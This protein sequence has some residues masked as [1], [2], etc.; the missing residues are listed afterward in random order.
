MTAF[1]IQASSEKGID[2][3]KLI[4]KYGCFP[5]TQEMLYA[6]R[7]CLV[8]KLT[9]FYAEEFSSVKETYLKCWTST[10]SMSHFI[11]TQDVAQ[12]R[13]L[14]I[15][16]TQYLSCS[17]STCRMR[18]TFHLSSKSQMMKSTSTDLRTS[19]R[20]PKV[21]R[22]WESKTLRTSSLLGLILRRLSSS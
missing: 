6:L 16:D 8:W 2:Y 13:K 15:L 4:D 14:F 9:G 18:S 21:Q 19:S 22:R 5:I 17:Q 7:I 20:A 1:D 10:K 3:D 12:V 11:S